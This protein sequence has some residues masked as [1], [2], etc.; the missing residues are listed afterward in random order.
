MPRAS[1]NFSI[2]SKTIHG[3]TYV[4]ASDVAKYYGMRIW[5]SGKSVVLFGNDQRIDL[6]LQRREA[7]INSLQVHLSFAPVLDG[8]RTMI[9]ER[10][11]TLLIDPILRDWG[12]PAFRVRRIVIDAGHGGKDNGAEGRKSKEKVLTLQ[13]AKRLQAILQPKGYEVILTRGD[14]RFLELTSRPAV[15]NRHKADIFVSIHFNAVATNSVHG[16]E[17]YVLTPEDT[18]STPNSSAESTSVPGNRHDQLNHR[19]GYEIHRH[20]ISTTKAQDR[21]L[22]RH[23][24]AVLRTAECPSVLLELGFVTNAAEERNV[25]SDAYQQQLAVAIANGIISYDRVGYRNS[26]RGR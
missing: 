21:G 16:I 19:L 23:R 22:K 18:P 24:W 4:R 7:R 17:T 6:T 10:D 8:D 11:F 26:Q 25:T 14:D 12:L 3:R 2:Y 1:A 9:A 15:A 20:L 13:M 5:H